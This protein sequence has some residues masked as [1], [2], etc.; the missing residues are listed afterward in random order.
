MRITATDNTDTD[1]VNQFCQATDFNVTGL[2][3]NGIPAGNSWAAP[4][5]LPPDHSQMS[6]T[7]TASGVGARVGGTDWWWTVFERDVP[8][9][10]DLM[11]SEMKATALGAGN[12]GAWNMVITFYLYLTQPSNQVAGPYE[13]SGET[14]PDIIKVLA[15]G[16]WGG[17]YM[18][19]TNGI[20][21]A[22]T[23]PP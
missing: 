8:G 10:D 17:D 19:S 11:W 13:N 16:Y 23:A 6:F 7:F 3:I 14:N 4:V 18:T 20:F 9:P 22:A 1:E 21:A 5:I 12:N 15:E 2:A